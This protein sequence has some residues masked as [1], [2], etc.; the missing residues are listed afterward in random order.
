MTARL[1]VTVDTE[2]EGLWEN[3]Y[4]ATGNTTENIRGIPRFQQLCKRFQLRPSYLVDAPVVQDDVA[5]GIL[6]EIAGV[7]DC[8]IG[9]HMHPWCN[10]PLGEQSGPN[11]SFL[12]NLPEQVQ[13]DKLTWL[14]DAIHDRFGQRPTS[15]RAGRYGLDICGANILRSLG[16][17]VD[18]SVIPFTDYSD[19]GGPDFLGAPCEPYYVGPDDLTSVGEPGGLIEVPLSVGFSRPDFSRA[20]ALRQAAMKPALKSMRAV[21]LLDRLGIARRIKFSPE[22][23]SSER[24]RQLVDACLARNAPVMVMMFHSTSL[25]PGYSPYV[26]SIEKLEAFYRRLEQTFEYCLGQAG[27]APATLGEFAESFSERNQTS[28]VTPLTDS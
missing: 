8:E 20:Q 28:A 21:G 13:R 24:L 14:T 25:V 26:K 16:Y 2:E 11:A 4:R 7:G 12:S 6:A 10:P 22:Q 3:K 27:L 19:Q 5:S 18:S 1:I 9:A 15:F 23:S 17:R